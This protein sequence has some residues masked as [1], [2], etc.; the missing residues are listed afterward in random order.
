MAPFAW[1][2]EALAALPVSRPSATEGRYP[3][4]TRLRGITWDHPRA[5][6]P[7]RAMAENFAQEARIDI[8]WDVR[9]LQ[10]FA[11]FPLSELA[12]EYD[13][14]V[15]DHP[16]VG[17]AAQD[18]YLQPL[19]RLVD[20]RLLARVAAGSVGPSHASYR[21]D[22]HQWA[23]AV[24]AAAH[25]CAY[26]PDLL[27]EIGRIPPGSWR[28][29]LDLASDLRDRGLWIGMPLAPI[30]CFCA[31]ATLCAN[32]GEPPFRQDAVVPLA[33]GLQAL[34]MLR[35]LKDIAHPE[36]MR[37]NPIQLLERMA[38]GDEIVFVPMLFGYNNYSRPGFRP[39]IVRFGPLPS[40]GHGPVGLLGGAGIGISAASDHPDLAARYIEFCASD[41]GQRT[42]IEAGGQSGY[43]RFWLDPEV[44]QQCA[45][46]FFATLETLDRAY[47]RPRYPGF[48][49][50]QTRIGDLL[51]EYL[52]DPGEDAATV[53]ARMDDL[54]R[55]S[56]KPSTA[57]NLK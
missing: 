38:A 54:Y 22:G 48:V 30:D 50:L 17:E 42:T 10:D 8:S 55:K 1:A 19:D 46:F 25:V 24:D 16:F 21:W 14:L 49:Q 40:A 7:L 57:T 41:I 23:L 6:E 39:K 27:D 18:S 36:A 33:T 9:T 31:F 44:N 11:D 43:R 34:G 52:R 5:Y 20:V 29:T 47:L 53:L 12:Q 35:E 26:R 15:F 37:L 4:M 3:S 51:H 32:F 2:D 28:E 13:L 56:L 45:D